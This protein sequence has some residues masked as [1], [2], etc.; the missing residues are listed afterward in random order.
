MSRVVVVTGASCEVGRA[1]SGTHYL[2]AS[3]ED[4]GGVPGPLGDPVGHPDVGG[5]RALGSRLLG[6]LVIVA[7]S[8][9]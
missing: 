6:P 3:G 9:R 8:M 5:G 2:V 1:T 4:G 7:G